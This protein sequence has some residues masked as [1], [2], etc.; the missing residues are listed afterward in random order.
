[1]LCFGLT[2]CIAASE[3]AV[4]HFLLPH[5]EKSLATCCHRKPVMTSCHCLWAGLPLKLLFGLPGEVSKTLGG[6]TAIIS[7]YD[8]M[9]GPQHLD[10]LSLSSSPKVCVVFELF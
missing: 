3:R 9:V 2:D 5:Q 7:H 10:L 1:M 8:P 4:I 6:G